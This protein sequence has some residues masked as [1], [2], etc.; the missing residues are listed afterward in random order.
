MT[1][2]RSLPLAT[3]RHAMPGEAIQVVITEGGRE[4]AATHGEDYL[5]GLAELIIRAV[6]VNRIARERQAELKD[7]RRDCRGP[8]MARQR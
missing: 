8:D 7:M 5:L 1:D 6:R 3:I 4:H 2:I